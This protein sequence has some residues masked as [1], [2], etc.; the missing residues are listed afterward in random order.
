MVLVPDLI[1]LQE[2][3]YFIELLLQVG[4]FFILVGHFFILSRD[5]LLLFV[6]SNDQR[7]HG[8]CLV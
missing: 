3:F 1:F 7:T 8:C 6:F 4:Y 5:D 2:Y